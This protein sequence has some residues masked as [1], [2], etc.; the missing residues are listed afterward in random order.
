MDGDYVAVLHAQVVADNSVYPR[1]TVIEIVICQHDEDRVLALLTLDK[2]RVAT[3]QLE[4]LHGVVGEGD[5]G[6]VIVDGISDATPL[7]VSSFGTHGDSEFSYMSEL[8]FFFFLRMAVATSSSCGGLAGLIAGLSGSLPTVLC[9]PP[10]G[11]LGMSVAVTASGERGAARQTYLDR[12]TLGLVWSGSADMVRGQGVVS[13]TNCEY[14]QKLSSA[15][16]MREAC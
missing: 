16:E 3:E 4:R 9:S 7:L 5:D 12:S 15:R 8:G 10:E 2:D 13:E 6:V 14:V 1:G 11:S